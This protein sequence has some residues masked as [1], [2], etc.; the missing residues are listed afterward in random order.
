MNSLV[1]ARVT[2]AHKDMEP[3]IECLSV[4]KKAEGFG[5]LVGG[6]TTKCPLHVCRAFVTAL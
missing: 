6:Y 5:E 1:Y 4:R 3:E 2:L